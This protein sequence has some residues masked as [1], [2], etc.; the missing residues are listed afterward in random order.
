MIAFLQMLQLILIVIEIFVVLA[1]LII[2]LDFVW[3]ATKGIRETRQFRRLQ[4]KR[5]EAKAW[6]RQLKEET[7]YKSFFNDDNYICGFDSEGNLV[8]GE[9]LH[10]HHPTTAQAKKLFDEM[11]AIVKDESKRVAAGVPADA[12]DRIFT[13]TKEL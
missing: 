11:D 8:L 5:D 13:N 1:I 3:D 4:A 6:I 7:A 10:P 9:W 2:L 12:D